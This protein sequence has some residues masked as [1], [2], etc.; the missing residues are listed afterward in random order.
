M[1]KIS[2][3]IL[4]VFMMLSMVFSTSV[5]AANDATTKTS[6]WDSFVGLFTKATATT[7]TMSV[8]YRGHI[9]DIGNAPTDGSW[10]QSDQ[11][12]GT[13]GESK[14]IEGFNIELTGA[15]PTGAH[16][17]YNVH[18]ENVGW[19]YPTDDSTNW[20]KDGAFAGSVGKSQ[21]VEA[22]EIKLVDAT[23]AQL[24]GY[25]V[26]YT[27]HGENYGWTQGWISDGNIA[28][29]TGDGLRLEAIRIKVTQVAA[30]LTAYNAAIAAV[31]QADYTTAS[32]TT[33][34][35]VVAANPAATTDTQSKVDTATANIVAAQGN[36]VLVPKVTSV[37]AVNAKQI[38]VTYN[39]N[40]DKTTAET[41]GNY[42]LSAA[43]AD[44]VGTITVGTAKVQDDKKTVILDI[45]ATPLNSKTTANYFVKVSGVKE[46]AG[47]LFGDYAQVVTLFDA[48]SPTV[49]SVALSDSNTIKVTFS[50]PINTNNSGAAS[51]IKFTLDSVN[52]S[53]PATAY[54]LSTDK[55]SVE[56]NVATAGLTAE[57]TYG[58]TVDGLT[59][60]ASNALVTYTTTVYITKDTTKPTV[61][62]VTALSLQDVK[63]V[64]SEKIAN[65]I[66]GFN[67][68]VD[69]TPSIASVQDE[70]TTTPDG[71]SFI[72]HLNS[73]KT[74]ANHIVAVYSYYDLAN[75]AGE[76]KT[77]EIKFAASKPVLV[78]ST[79]TIK[80][81]AGVTYAIYTFDRSVLQTV[82][83]IANVPYVDVNG[84]TQHTTLTIGDY[85]DIVGLEKTQIAVE[86]SS[87]ATGTYNFTFVKGAVE[88][89][90]SQQADEM[91]LSF[92]KD[93]VAAK[94]TVSSVKTNTVA[95]TNTLNKVTVTFVGDVDI[96][97]LDATHYTI[98]GIQ[99]FETGSAIYDGN[100][101]TVTLT[102]KDG[103]LTTSGN[104]TFNVT[105]VTNVTNYS[106]SLTF[107]ENVKP[108]VVK[109]ELIAYDK[110]KLSLSEPVTVSS[111]G[112]AAGLEVYVN[113]VKTTTDV[114]ITGS[115]TDKLTITLATADK[116]TSSTT[117]L[118]VSI[119]STNN[120]TDATT[121][122]MA[123]TDLTNIAVAFTDT[124]LDYT[125]A[126]TAMDTAM[127]KDLTLSSNLVAAKLAITN[128]ITAKNAAAAVTAY[129][130][131]ISDSQAIV[132]AI[133]T[134][135]AAKDTAATSAA[136]TTTATTAVLTTAK[137][138]ITAVGT[139]K[140]AVDSAITT[141]TGVGHTMVL[142]TLSSALA[143][144]AT[145]VTTADKAIVK[146]NMVDNFDVTLA[147][148]QSANKGQLTFV[149]PWIAGVNAS[150]LK[151]N[152]TV[153]G[154][155]N[156]T[157]G[158]PP[159]ATALTFSTDHYV[160]STVGANDAT[161]RTATITLFTNDTLSAYFGISVADAV[162]VTGPV[163]A[164]MV[165]GP[166]ALT[167]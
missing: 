35:A 59:D 115:G 101:R 25:S 135:V 50:E 141:A 55:K 23:G 24:P 11:Q 58:L 121:N 110:I 62:S 161:A 134:Y 151:A 97:A 100:K 162:T 68:N 13:T 81:I 39:K 148:D 144:D 139:A 142:G 111:T 122:V 18:V 63:V 92:V 114:T 160:L 146:P 137:N 14:R 79:A 152:F 1:K 165:A 93:A 138:D 103:A 32:W 153:A 75:N 91:K 22:I 119:L 21:R 48:V 82:N 7:D 99:A 154:T 149:A 163:T 83:T 3:S 150:D 37:T 41:T 49:T 90:Y 43:N 54:T 167:K 98:D 52:V 31:N 106:S 16:V 71:K 116:L 84:V 38:L 123:A 147:A 64:F 143:T 76:T 77:Q 20:I 88:D 66:S 132:G 130:L 109:S 145:A 89:L 105:N 102:L 140:T 2:V 124:A 4:S 56:I 158:A 112:T 159:S 60:F 117:P 126:I 87:Q 42:T 164:S 156:P 104:K 19:L 95:G 12:L 46:F 61:E 133:D 72:V 33:Y 44:A 10:V 5:F 27:V 78:S 8:Q 17:V 47:T 6:A 118:K 65:G 69:G 94:T 127:N 57:K 113:G 155:F 70:N 166:I 131:E 34:Q 128:A 108:V 85:T 120:L 36:L 29:T 73:A 53:V 96:S 86:L 125:N 45:E 26:Q 136:G 80:D 9:Q 107:R 40:V 15:I 28:G 74:A 67:L 129:A 51:A 30:D 157:T